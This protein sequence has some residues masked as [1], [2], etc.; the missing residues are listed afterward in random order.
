MAPYEA[1]DYVKVELA[2]K[3][4]GEREQV[5]VRVERSDEENRVVFGRVDSEPVVFA[6]E[7]SLGQEVAVSFEKIREHKKPQDF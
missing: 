7:L 1:G 6:S 3:A 4:R 2:D 5:W